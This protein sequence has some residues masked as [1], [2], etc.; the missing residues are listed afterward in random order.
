VPRTPTKEQKEKRWPP[1]TPCI[2]Q[3]TIPPEHMWLY[4]ESWKPMREGVRFVAEPEIDDR[5][6][7]AMGRQLMMPSEAH[8]RAVT[9][10]S[11]CLE[12]LK[13]IDPE[14]SFLVLVEIEH[15]ET[16]YGEPPELLFSYATMVIHDDDQDQAQ[17]VRD[18]PY[19]RRPPACDGPC[20]GIILHTN[21]KSCDLG[22]PCS[23]Q[24]CCQ[25]CKNRHQD[26]MHAE[27]PSV[28]KRQ[29]QNKKKHERQRNN[30]Q[31]LKLIAAATCEQEL[32]DTPATKAQIE[33]T[34]GGKCAF[35]HN[36]AQWAKRA[37]REFIKAT[38]AQSQADFVQHPTFAVGASLEEQASSSSL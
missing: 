9:M 3:L 32:P 5:C 14:R 25:E 33:A 6:R 24:F 17:L 21:I 26:K 16:Y 1:N 28:V 37:R 2:L 29:A 22:S 19:K 8:K 30:K 15:S 11:D 23:G 38:R 12:K 18:G 31:L 35:R 7:E 20:Q 4:L 27:H 36:E 10:W 13:Q 34:K